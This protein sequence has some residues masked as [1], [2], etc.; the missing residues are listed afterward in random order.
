MTAGEGT[1]KDGTRR[2]GSPEDG[3][4]R[5]GPREEKGTA[6]SGGRTPGAAGASEEPGGGD[7]RE[8]PVAG[9]GS[10]DS[11]S[12]DAAP[13]DPAP[14]EDPVPAAPAA[15]DP[16]FDEDDVRALFRGAVGGLTPG[17]GAL[18]RLQAA[19]PARRAR[20]RQTLVGVAAAV[21]L[22]GTAIPAAVH[23]AAAP[24]HEADPAMAGSSQD[25]RTP[26]SAGT[27][28]HESDEHEENG[29]R[30]ASPH[31]SA[32]GR[33][34]D[35]GSGAPEPGTHPS[36]GT[37]FAD[38]PR[39][40]PTQLG[41][42]AADRGSPAA[43]GTVYGSFRVANISGE[44][45]AVTS[46]GEVQVVVLGG[47][48]RTTVPVVQHQEG[49]AAGG[50]PG[51]SRS[52]QALLLDPGQSYEVR[53]A[54]VPDSTCPSGGP[55]QAPGDPDPSSPP[56]V[57]PSQ[58]PAEGGGSGSS[59]DNAAPLDQTTTQFSRR[60]PVDDTPPTAT[61]EVTH[62]AAPGGPVTNTT[63]PDSC[64]GTLYRTGLLPA[65]GG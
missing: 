27:E 19:V 12:A 8:T 6:V 65:D 40:E 53:F 14:E 43:D 7:A 13:V 39:C 42:A 34:R 59:P 30:S 2:E 21:V 52:V 26:S 41:D 18:D 45:C 29:G 49:D 57:D 36:A 48:A 24:G 64:P 9:P 38:A 20:K 63:I 55:T 5:E 44:K 58:P 32:G 62:N 11:P 23:V 3:A 33:H 35:T 51:P 4:R 17:E 60:V 15:P 61:V 1:R 28:R 47:A 22:L 31:S 56:P 25:A 37:V 16:S 10:A 54:F 46:P 50:L